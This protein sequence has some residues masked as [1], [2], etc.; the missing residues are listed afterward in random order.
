MDKT[1]EEKCDD[2]DAQIER[3]EDEYERLFGVPISSIQ[4]DK[5]YDYVINN[6]SEENADTLEEYNKRWEI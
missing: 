1:F 2:L 3:L 5:M 6:L 4:L